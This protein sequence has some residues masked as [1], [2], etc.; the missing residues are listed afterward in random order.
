MHY[1]NSVSHIAE[2]HSQEIEHGNAK[3]EKHVM[4]NNQCKKAISIHIISCCD[5]N[6]TRN[7]QHSR[8]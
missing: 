8:S 7:T 2:V 6:F 4:L 5:Y 3:K 1:Q